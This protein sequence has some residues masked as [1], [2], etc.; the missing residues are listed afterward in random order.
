M[1]LNPIRLCTGQRS[2]AADGAEGRRGSGDRWERKGSCGRPGGSAERRL[3]SGLLLYC[4]QLPRIANRGVAAPNSALVTWP[5][6]RRESQRF[7]D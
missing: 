6:A 2:R 5:E 1:L 3:A 4:S 7:H